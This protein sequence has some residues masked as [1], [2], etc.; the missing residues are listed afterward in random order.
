MKVSDI[1][2]DILRAI[3]AYDGERVVW[4]VGPQAGEPVPMSLNEGYR[5]FRFGTATLFEHRLVW[6]LVHGSWPAAL[7][8]H[9]DRDK[10]NNRL[11][12]LRE[13]TAAQNSQNVGPSRRS[14]SGV[15]GV[16]WWAARGKW[17]ANIEA[18]GKR[19]WLGTFESFDDAVSAR[20]AAE[21]DLHP[22]A[23]H[24]S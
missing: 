7:L 4:A 19:R 21:I 14:K 13:A 8:D 20:R 5:V 17:A 12:N 10:L 24:V 16:F 6:A 3:F 23:S 1:P 18:A 9:K 2:L 15:R 22:F 11:S